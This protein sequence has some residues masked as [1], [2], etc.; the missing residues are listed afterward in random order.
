MPPVRFHTTCGDN[1]QLLDD[2]MVA[3][4]QTSF[5]HAITFS[6]K[7]LHPME[8]FLIEIEK[9]E[10]GWSG[11]LRIGL[12]QHNPAEKRSLPQYALPDLANMGKSWIFAV[13]KSHNKILDP[14]ENQVKSRTRS[15]SNPSIFGEGEFIQ[16]YMGYIN[17]N[18]LKPVPRLFPMDTN[19]SEEGPSMSVINFDVGSQDSTDSADSD[20]LPTDTGSRIGIVYIVRNNLAEMHFIING[21]DQ[22]VYAKDIPYSD[23]PLYAMVDVY[24]TTKQVRIVQLYGGTELAFFLSWVFGFAFISKPMYFKKYEK[25]FQTLNV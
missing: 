5:A 25:F 24:G 1:I 3:Y 13:T 12:T 15:K 11:H 23:G 9:N 14:D 17:R 22:G 20:I 6:E 2:N 4:R 16:T 21:E 7:P 19:G 18:V 8:I 10:R